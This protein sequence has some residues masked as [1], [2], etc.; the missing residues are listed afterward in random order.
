[1]SNPAAFERTQ[2]IKILPKDRVPK[3][4]KKLK[5]IVF[6]W[7]M[8]QTYSTDLRKIHR[9]SKLK[10]YSFFHIRRKALGEIF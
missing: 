8:V 9:K 5:L 3:N 1:M 10:S 4:K 6:L 7:L 2:E